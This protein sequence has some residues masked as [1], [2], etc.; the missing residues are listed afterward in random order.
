[1][2]L[3]LVWLLLIVLMLF[4]CFSPR[5]NSKERQLCREKISYWETYKGAVKARQINIP[6]RPILFLRFKL[7]MV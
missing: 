6:G 7:F 4:L 1:M 2:L 5:K 3:S